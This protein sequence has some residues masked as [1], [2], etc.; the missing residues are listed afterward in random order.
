MNRALLDTD[1]L[2]ELIK[3]RN[4]SVLTAARSYIDQHRVF[5]ITCV[6][7]YEA[8]SG[9]IAINAPKQRAQLDQFVQSN[10][11]IIPDEHD[12]RLAAAIVGSLQR[13]GKLVG[14][15]DPLIAACAVNR[16]MDLCTG[17]ERHYQLIADG[18]FPIQIVNWRNA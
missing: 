3:A 16:Q 15:A 14:F 8:L 5:T 11:L 13:S 18:G 17:N 2:S 1:I 9:L 12:Y 4:S 6:T 7:L 10:D